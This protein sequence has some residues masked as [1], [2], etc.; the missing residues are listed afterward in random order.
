MQERRSVR[1][2]AW[3]GRVT[4]IV[5]DATLRLDAVDLS[6]GG[7]GLQPPP[8]T[9]SPATRT[10]ALLYVDPPGGG[11]PFLC[12]GETRGAGERWG[13]RFTCAPEGTLR[14]LTGG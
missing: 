2:Q 9:R 12:L 14:S 7:I 8:G 4:A 5:G 1:R 13:V 11:A 3:A 6:V 10:P